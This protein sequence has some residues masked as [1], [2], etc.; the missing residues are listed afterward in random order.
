M[1]CS[2]S[3]PPPPASANT[4]ARLAR[5]V[6]ERADERADRRAQL[7]LGLGLD[8]GDRLGDGGEQLVGDAVEDGEEQRRL[9]RK[10]S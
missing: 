5:V 7:R 1:C 4:I 6:G 3:A 8:R 2:T 9:S 10:D